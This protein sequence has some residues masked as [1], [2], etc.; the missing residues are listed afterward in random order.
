MRALLKRELNSFFNTLTGYIVIAVFLILVSLFLW[1]IPASYNIIDAGYADLDGLF[2]LAPLVFLFLV[3]ALTMRFFSDEIRTGTLEMLITKPLTEWHIVFSKYLAGIIL[4]L[5]ALL[6][7]LVYLATVQLFAVSPGVDMGGT[8]GSYAGLLFLGMVFVSVG[9]FASALTDNQIVAFIVALFL[10]FFLY[11]GFEMIA[12][13]GFGG[14]TD[15]FLRDLG[16]Q[17][18]Y[19]SMSR[20]V[21]DTRDLFYFIGII[22]IFLTLTW[23]KLSWRSNKRNTS[24]I[25]ALGVLLLVVAINLA[26]SKGFARFDLTSEKRY[27]LTEASKNMLATLDDVVYFRVYLDGDLPAEFRRLQNQTREMLDEMQAYSDYIQVDFISP[28]RAAGDDHSRLQE[29]YRSLAEKGLEP[30]EVMIQTSDGASQQVIIPGAIVTYGDKELPLQLMQDHIGLSIRESIHRSGMLLE[31]NIA[32]VIQQITRKEPVRIAF[33]EGHGQLEPQYLASVTEALER[34]YDV[35]RIHPGEGLAAMSEYKTLISARPLEP[36]TEQEKFLLDQYLMQGGHMLWLVDPVFADMDSLRYGPETMGIAWD[37]NM[38]DFF[39][40][41]GARLNPVLIQDLHAARIPKQVG[42]VSGRPRFDLQEWYFFPVLNP[43][44]D[45]EIVKNLN[46]IRTEFPASIDTV[47]A[48]GVDKH[49]L[50]QSSQYT[51]SLPVPVRISLELL[52]DPPDPARFTGPP[53]NVAVLLEGGFESLFK[54]RMIPDMELPAD[55]QRR[56]YSQPS[57]MIVIA[58]GHVIKNQVRMDGEAMPLGYYSYTGQTFGNKD[59]ILNAVNYLADDSGIIEA[60]AKD[61]RMRLLDQSRIREQRSAVQF[62]NV[63]LPVLLL[64]IFGIVRYL[65]RKRRYAK[66]PARHE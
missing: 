61:V 50:L 62:F 17:A 59:L 65:Y 4:L 39:F 19:T 22:A 6:P 64:V 16:L 48:K 58:D 5:A 34:F 23:V 52:Y 9:I 43:V 18:H 38:D 11:L 33:L 29:L 8:W 66:P 20:G 37:I 40:T 2:V 36:Y 56:D 10:S 51:R 31:Y 41:Y 14:Q 49:I 53:A 55:F 47:T 26:G 3:P 7:T 13:M 42:S 35:E 63:G 30:A 25:K 28:S 12:N 21:L 60:R 1:V 27:S 57:S 45:H 15:L 54:N 24:L 44:S 46:L 32:S